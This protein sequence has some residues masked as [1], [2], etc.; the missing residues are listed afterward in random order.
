M[1]RI[2]NFLK[3]YYSDF[4]IQV[5]TLILSYNIFRPIDQSAVP[6]SPFSFK[7]YHVIEK[8]VGVLF[9]FFFINIIL[10]K[11]FIKDNK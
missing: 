8:V 5:G 4:L 9:F 6:P 2:F 7:D 11:Y 1:K 10:R 3:N